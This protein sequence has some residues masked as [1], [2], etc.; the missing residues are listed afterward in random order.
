MCFKVK[1]KNKM[2]EKYN[3][4][5]K[6]NKTIRVKLRFNKIKFRNNNKISR[7]KKKN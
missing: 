4:I 7:I 6:L 5:K 3:K 1:N 2:K